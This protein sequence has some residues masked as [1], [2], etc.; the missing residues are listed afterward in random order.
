MWTIQTDTALIKKKYFLFAWKNMK[1]ALLISPLMILFGLLF[2]KV[3]FT[4]EAVKEKVL[5]LKESIE[6]PELDVLLTDYSMLKKEVEKRQAA[7]EIWE[8]VMNLFLINVGLRLDQK[9]SLQEILVKTCHSKNI[10]P[11][12]TTPTNVVKEE[13]EKIT[14]NKPIE[15][16]DTTSNIDMPSLE[17][18]NL[19]ESDELS[20]NYQRKLNKINKKLFKNNIIKKPGQYL[21]KAMPIVGA[22]Q[23]PKGL[24]GNFFGGVKLKSDKRW[25][26]NFEVSYKEKHKIWYGNYKIQ[27][28]D[29]ENKVIKSKKRINKH[30]IYI[31]R[32]PLDPKSFVVEVPGDMFFHFRSTKIKNKNMKVFEG[33]FYKRKKNK[34]NSYSYR[35]KFFIKQDIVI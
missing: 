25:S 3:F 29:L 5:P 7:H 27:I 13:E 32:H 17:I 8:K 31:L 30:N 14:S 26:I 18:N 12:P 6:A 10:H 24:S 11:T 20:L 19:K 15:Q 28:K 4:P 21:K 9:D 23:W 16:N 1:I 35:G 2:G 22:S 34:D 33:T